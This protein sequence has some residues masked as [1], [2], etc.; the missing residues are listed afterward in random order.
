MLNFG[1]KLEWVVRDL[2]ILPPSPSYLGKTSD[3]PFTGSWVGL[4]SL[5]TGQKISFPVGFKIPI[6]QA[7]SE[8]LYRLSYPGRQYRENT[9][10]NFS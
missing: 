10:A 2:A 7:R 4:G 5:W 1:L 3:I 9:S 8:P 6:R